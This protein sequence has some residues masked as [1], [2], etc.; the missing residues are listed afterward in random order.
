M[1]V[2]PVS[3]AAVSAT[4]I[5]GVWMMSGIGILLSILPDHID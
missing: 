1:H 5:E 2:W 4:H 3:G